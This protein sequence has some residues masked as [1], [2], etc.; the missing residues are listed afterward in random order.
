MLVTAECIYNSIKKLPEDS[1]NLV[2]IFN[3]FWYKHESYDP[4]GELEKEGITK[5]K[6]RNLLEVDKKIL[7]SVY[8]GTYKYEE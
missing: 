8:K 2:A 6:V 7:K 3:L 4:I 1:Y 5:D